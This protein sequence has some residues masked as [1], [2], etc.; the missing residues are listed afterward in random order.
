MDRRNA[1]ILSLPSEVVQQ[2]VAQHVQQISTYKEANDKIVSDSRPWMVYT[3][4][5]SALCKLALTC[6]AFLP[7]ARRMLYQ[8]VIL[9]PQS[10]P[11]KGNAL[12][13]PGVLSNIHA[14]NLESVDSLA[15]FLRTLFENPE[16][17]ELV[18]HL[19]CRML[20]SDV[21]GFKMMELVSYGFP[22]LTGP[23]HQLLSF[24]K[25]ARESWVRYSANMCIGTG[26]ASDIL[27]QTGLYDHGDPNLAQRMCA[28]ILYLTPNL[29]HLALEGLPCP[30]PTLDLNLD[31]F[32]YTCLDDLI[33][34]AL[35]ASGQS[36][37]IL[38]RL[39][40]LTIR[41]DYMSIGLIPTV[42]ERDRIGIANSMSSG[43]EEHPTGTLADCC[44]GLLRTPGLQRLTTYCNLRGWNEVSLL[45]PRLRQVTVHTDDPRDA[46]LAVCEQQPC[47]EELRLMD[48]KFK[49]SKTLL[50]SPTVT[51]QAVNQSMLRR[52]STLKV[53]ELSAPETL[54]GLFSPAAGSCCL[55]HLHQL[56]DLTI[57]ISLL[58][59][60]DNDW[61]ELET[62]DRTLPP[63]LITLKIDARLHASADNID[64]EAG[65]DCEQLEV[66]ANVL[67][68]QQSVYRRHLSRG[69][70][71]LAARCITVYP[72]LRRVSVVGFVLPWW[73][74]VCRTRPHELPPVRRVL[75][76]GPSLQSEFARA[77]VEFVTESRP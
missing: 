69:L 52:A 2:I 17:G 37:S 1:S 35:S 50:P 45:N 21:P 32:R 74:D 57:N 10:G 53:L 49:R 46:I 54:S 18:Q 4:A 44:P 63:G 6:K 42:Y 3:P 64:L 70:G 20:L 56:Q 61:A 24:E 38:P 75:V 55:P 7:V 48:A 58:A 71:N 15:L 33:T 39:W 66:D 59:S 29:Q 41:C 34:C 11:P 12:V 73:R 65:A 36:R 68:E 25:A 8:H 14:V 22:G 76:N 60:V 13:P 27:R 30:L 26:K 77:G 31:A 67:E 23:S 28:A 40:S 9:L 47:L 5:K 43:T 16:L 62:L 51:R 19:D 72:S